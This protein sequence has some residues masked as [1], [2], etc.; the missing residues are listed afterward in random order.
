MTLNRKSNG[1]NS[2]TT[3]FDDRSVAADSEEPA[4]ERLDAVDSGSAD[5]D[6]LDRVDSDAAVFDLLVTSPPLMEPPA[7]L[8]SASIVRKAELGRP[9]MGLE[10]IGLVRTRGGA[11]GLE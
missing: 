5:F 10:S 6:A 11:C 7:A 9:F 2:G 4:S 1:I 8:N 3:E